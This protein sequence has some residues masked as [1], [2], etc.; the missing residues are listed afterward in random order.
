MSIASKGLDQITAED[1]AGLVGSAPDPLHIA[2]LGKWSR[3]DA[4]AAA[5][6]LANAAGGLVIVGATVTEA[7]LFSAV[8]DLGPRGRYP[9]AAE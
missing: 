2:T 6:S 3:S 7:D 1:I 4:A 9:N 5:A 8:G